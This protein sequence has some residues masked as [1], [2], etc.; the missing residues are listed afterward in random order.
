M[1]THIYKQGDCLNNQY[2]SPSSGLLGF[3]CSLYFPL[4]HRIITWKRHLFQ[5]F[6]SIFHVLAVPFLGLPG[7]PALWDPPWKLFPTKLCLR[8]I[9]YLQVLGMPFPRGI[10]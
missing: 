2:L 9:G 7:F 10:F 5:L 4:A 8:K 6:C 1:H 3:G